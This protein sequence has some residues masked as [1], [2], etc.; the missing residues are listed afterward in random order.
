MNY[1]LHNM[2]HLASYGYDIIA[3]CLNID[4]LSKVYIFKLSTSQVELH[5]NSVL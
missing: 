4:H 2:G 1:A 5:H 3:I